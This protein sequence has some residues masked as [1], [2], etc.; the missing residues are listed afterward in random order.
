MLTDCE[1]IFVYGT[2]R[3][4]ARRS[5]EHLAPKKVTYWGRGWVNGLLYL[6][7]DWD[8]AY[9]GLIMPP[10]CGEVVYGEVYG[11]N[12][13]ALGNML[14]L[15]DEYEGCGPHDS[16]P[17][18]YRREQVAVQLMDHVVNPIVNSSGEQVTN[19]SGKQI[20]DKIANRTQVNCWVYLYNWPIAPAMLHLASGDFLNPS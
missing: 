15:L 18:E 1:Y 3:R 4:G 11:V 9:P 10:A 13:D 17:H 8:Y 16:Q 12:P 7:H 14:A 5:L 6:V 19:P 2:L 20:E